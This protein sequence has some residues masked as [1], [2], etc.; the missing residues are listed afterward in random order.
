MLNEIPPSFAT[1]VFNR[2]SPLRW[3]P[4]K[5]VFNSGIP[6]PAASGSTYD[7]SPPATAANAQ[8]TTACSNHATNRAYPS[9]PTL[10]PITPYRNKFS[11]STNPSITNATIP[12]TA[13]IITLVAHFHLCSRL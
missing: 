13:P 10:S 1:T 4:F 12:I 9:V 2:K 6:D 5:Y 11:L 8:L 3:T 7:T